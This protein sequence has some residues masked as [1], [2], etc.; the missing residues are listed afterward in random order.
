MFSSPWSEYF[1]KKKVMH[2]VEKIFSF[3]FKM[4]LSLFSSWNIQILTFLRNMEKLTLLVGISAILSIKMIYGLWYR[5]TLW[6]LTPLLR[7]LLRV[8][9]K[10]HKFFDIVETL[11]FAWKELKS[12]YNRTLI[13]ETWFFSHEIIPS[14][15]QNSDW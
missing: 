7:T 14:F 11:T 4:Y 5:H 9:C 10:K 6:N 15:Y 1:T 13:S 8:L 2:T 12:N 3:S